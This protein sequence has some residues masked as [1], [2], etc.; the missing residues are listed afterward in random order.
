MDVRELFL[1]CRKGDLEKVRTLV[2]QREVEI[3]VRDVWDSTPLYYACLCGHI[4]VVKFLLENGARCEANTFD[5]ERC[6][7][8]ALSPEIRHLLRNYKIICSR[9]IRRE[10]YTEFLR[11]LV[12][13]GEYS[14]VCFDVHGE[15]FHGHRCVLSARS[16]YFHDM[17]LDKWKD[18]TLIHIK[19]ELVRPQDFHAVLDY[20]YT[21]QL[22]T[23]VESIE[24]VIR[25]ARQCRLDDLVARLETMGNTA[26]LFQSTKPGTNVTTIAVESPENWD[27]QRDFSLLAE[28]AVPPEF[29]RWVGGT[30]L[31][32]PALP[33]PFSTF[34]DLV[35]RIGDWR[36]LCHRAFFCSRS[37]YFRAILR[38]PLGEEGVQLEGDVPVIPLRQFSPSVFIHILFYIYQDTVELDECSVE[39]VLIAADLCLLPGLKRQ[40]GLYMSQFLDPG[41]AVPAI[42][43]ARLFDLPRL[44][45]Q[46]YQ[47]IA[48]N[49]EL[50]VEEES[51]HELVREDAGSVRDRED[52]DS[53]DVVDN[54]RYHL[55]AASM[56]EAHDKLQLID[57]LLE[58]LALDA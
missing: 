49:L 31:P 10:Y 33:R 37:E 50:M 27:L 47:Y 4:E 5:G 9:T 29:R 51:L 58:S 3:N 1:S 28:T 30:E 39:E 42:R 14:D 48:Q 40:C 13:N 38:N 44:E 34:P 20:I 26:H 22:R 8:G 53:I 55:T 46:A 17:F 15:E 21:G 45:D 16:P 7:Y 19:H 24:D 35:F 32:F 36:F 57:S 52:V 6:L 18:K 2:E 25:L 11:K 54:L 41:N 56:A 12:E 23:R 43:I